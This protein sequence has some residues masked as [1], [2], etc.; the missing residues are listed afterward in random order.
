MVSADL[1]GIQDQGQ[2]SRRSN[3]LPRHTVSY[4]VVGT[5]HADFDGKIA[6]FLTKN[7]MFLH[8]K[9]ELGIREIQ[10]AH[11]FNRQ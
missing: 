10:Q 2:A 6:C 11:S 7:S 4:K 8:G 1:D 9:A 5:T 3:T